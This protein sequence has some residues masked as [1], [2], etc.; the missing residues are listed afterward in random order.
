MKRSTRVALLSARQQN[1]HSGERERRVD[2]PK[3]PTTAMMM[4]I[5]IWGNA[6]GELRKK[7]EPKE[8][9]E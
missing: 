1:A 8:E 9:T 2:K 4:K 7:C 5:V 6:A 3:K